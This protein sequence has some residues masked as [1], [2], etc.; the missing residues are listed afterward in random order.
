METLPGVVAPGSDGLSQP[1]TNEC[2]LVFKDVGLRMPLEETSGSITVAV[3]RISSLQ[4]ECELLDDVQAD[5]CDLIR[6]GIYLL[7]AEGHE[8][9]LPAAV[10]DPNKFHTERP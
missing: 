1:V 4:E 6:R 7:P 10:F 5:Q 3:A 9:Y 8:E 2:V